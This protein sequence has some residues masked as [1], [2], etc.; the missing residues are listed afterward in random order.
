MDDIQC[1]YMAVFYYG[2]SLYTGETI[3]IQDNEFN[4]LLLGFITNYYTKYYKIMD[5]VFDIRYSKERGYSYRINYDKIVKYGNL[6]ENDPR[7]FCQ[8]YDEV[9]QEMVDKIT[10]LACEFCKYV[11]IVNDMKNSKKIR[12]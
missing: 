1:K 3:G 4:Q 10:D 9:G 11:E 2:V 7:K 5:K 8:M 6:V 12:H